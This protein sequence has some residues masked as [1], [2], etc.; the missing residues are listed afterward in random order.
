MSP[1]HPD[2]ELLARTEDFNRKAD[3]FW[4]E[5]AADPSGRRHTLNK[6][7]SGIIAAPG[8]LYR[9]GLALEE[10]HLGAGLTVL[11]FGAGSCW[12]S[13]C[14]NRLGCRTIALDV[15]PA[16][17]ELG[18]ELF[19]LD[20]RHRP[21]LEPRFEVYDGHRIP[22]PDASVD[23]IACFDAF[24]H[25]PNQDEVLGEMFRVLREGGRAV[26]AEPGEGHT[27][28]D[29]AAFDTERYGVLENELD[30][31][32][33]ERRAR[34]AGFR[35]VSLKPYPD[36]GALS[37]SPRDYVRLMEGDPRP[38]PM[39]PL[40][41]SLRSNFIVVLQKGRAVRDSRGPGRLRARLEL[42]DPQGPLV[43]RGGT[44]LTLLVAAWNEGDTLWRHG[45]DPL[46]GSVMLGSHLLDEWRRVIRADFARTELSV[47]VPPG[48]VI[49]ILAHVPVPPDP[50]RYVLRLDLV[51]DQV[52][53][54][55]QMG[56]PTLDLDLEIKSEVEAPSL[57]AEIAAVEAGPLRVP[58]GVR[59]APVLRVTNTG[60]CRWPHS[61][62]PGP[63]AIRL[64]GQLLSAEGELLD[65]DFLRESLP[66]EVAVGG[67]VT[68]PARFRAPLEPG[69]YVLKIDLVQEC[70]CWFEE[71]GSR[72]L[73]LALEVTDEV[74]DSADPGVLRA[75][76]ELLLPES[77]LRSRP[78]AR[79]PLL[80][81]ATNRG[82]TLWLHE[83]RPSGG[84]VALGG[85]LLA[86]GTSTPVDYLRVL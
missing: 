39:A 22:L 45:I 68:T 82:N 25:V 66:G 51:D 74:P 48:A 43:A 85:R 56:S 44:T 18:R 20:P 6:P 19:R 37:V 34:A 61:P 54:F 40:Q 30:I 80:L 46:G 2:E 23:R 76:L 10:L 72:P 24:H 47:D 77:T 81:R 75:S 21:E 78:K 64:A 67:S 16:A 55:S 7:F 33:V 8:I 50:G 3:T 53:W 36:P 28:S 79:V 60:S 38:F 69:S 13:S 35:E 15:S 63:Y 65:R 62:T 9:L 4:L 70:V 5:L 41:Q 52:A 58:A 59:R 27:H 84:H 29:H 31:L 49:Q 26:L 32:D 42:I 14:L 1:R 57:R 17:L 86:E 83:R 73:R 12:F 71:R 11:D